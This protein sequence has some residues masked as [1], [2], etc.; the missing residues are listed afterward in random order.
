MVPAEEKN[1]KEIKKTKIMI[2]FTIPLGV[3]VTITL[4]VL[5]VIPYMKGIN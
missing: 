4:L 2:A 1:P 3:L 5:W